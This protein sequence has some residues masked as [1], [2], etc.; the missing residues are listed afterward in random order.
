MRG[1]GRAVVAGVFV[2]LVLLAGVR[3]LLAPGPAEPAEGGTAGVAAGADAA[4]VEFR[5]EAGEGLAAVAE[6]L[7]DEGLVRSAVRLRILARLTRRDRAIQAGTYG[8]ERGTSPLALLD[9][10]TKGRVLLRRVTVPEGWRVAQIAAEVERALGVP[11]AEIESE[12][13]S[14]ARR[15]ALG[16]PAPTLE[17][18]LYPDTYRFPDEATAADVVDSMTERFLEIWYGIA[19]HAQGKIDRHAMVTLAS[20]IEAETSLAEERPRVS[21]V[22]HNRL[23]RGMLLQADPTVRYGL[24]RFEGRLYY[25]HLEDDSPWNT[26]RFPGLPPGPIGS[27][28]RTAL[29]AA[30]TPLMPCDDLY[31]V[32]SGSGGHVFSRTKAEHDRAVR[33]ARRK[34]GR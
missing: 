8:V 12:A 5:I 11:A 6:R 34:R 19:G 33:E 29:K 2:G 1:A 13:S 17:G 16:C 28:G 26:Y 30:L 4:G 21:A 18:Y 15:S 22:Y 7:E 20:I 32:A 24:G 14:E 23:Q 10:L 25:K 9:E 31:F 3:W 27:P